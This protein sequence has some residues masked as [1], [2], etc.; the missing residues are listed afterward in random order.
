MV[1]CTWVRPE[2]SVESA[3]ASAA[4]VPAEPLATAPFVAAGA[5]SPDSVAPVS[6]APVAAPASTSV[7]TGAWA[8]S[9]ARVAARLGS[10]GKLGSVRRCGV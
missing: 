4:A 3:E 8:A 1:D 7:A 9:E 10:P 6:G 2:G 5:A